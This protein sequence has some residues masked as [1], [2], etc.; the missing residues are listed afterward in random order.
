VPAAHGSE[1]VGGFPHP[2]SHG[3]PDSIA[4]ARTR[5]GYRRIAD[6]L[7]DANKSRH[8][9]HGRRH[10][11]E[12]RVAQPQPTADRGGDDA[13]ESGADPVADGGRP[14]HAAAGDNG[15]TPPLYAE[16]P[17]PPASG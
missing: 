12:P 1:P 7:Q 10:A 3:P 9:R 16:R 4:V 17:I 13:S 5:G 8:S 11:R 15:S 2:D 6:T 14:S